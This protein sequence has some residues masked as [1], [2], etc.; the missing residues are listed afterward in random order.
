VVRI[1]VVP[2]AGFTGGYMTEYRGIDYGLGRSNIGENGI[3]YGVIPLHD[4]AQSWCDSSEAIYPEP[5]KEYDEDGEEIEPADDDMDCVEPIGF[6]YSAD[7]YE[8][9]QSADD[10]DIFILKSPF[11]TVAQFC[12]PCAPGACHLRNP[13]EVTDDAAPADPNRC[14]CFGHDWFDEEEAPYPVYEVATGK[15]VYPDKK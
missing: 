7:G 3:R 6:R 11:F 5:E 10:S 2:G 12:S 14:Y 13:I 15:R 1:G 8:A 4:V 9:T